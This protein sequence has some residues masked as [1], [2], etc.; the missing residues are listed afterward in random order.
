MLALVRVATSL[1]A[2]LPLFVWGS[3]AHP[4]IAAACAAAALA[5]AGW[6]AQ[7]VRRVGTL[8]DRPLV[9]VDVLF[10]LALMLAGTR[11]VVPHDHNVIATELVP[12]MLASAA[13]VGFGFMFGIFQAVAVAALMAGWVL[14]VIPDVTLKL[15]SDL[16]GFALWYV[17]AA[18]SMREFRA[19]ALRTDQAQQAAQESAVA[20]EAARQRERIHGEV[21]GRLLPIVERLIVGEPVT[22]QTISEARRAAR[23]ARQLIADP[24][25]GAELAGAPAGFA[26]ML[27]ETIDSCAGRLA[28]EP[29]LVITAEPGTELAEALCTAV[30]E[31]LRNVSRHAGPQPRA[32]LYVESTAE[33]GQVTVRDR[34]PGFDLA[35]IR[36]GGGFAS[37]FPAL[38]RHGADWHADSVPGR[39]T[40]V[41]ITWTPAEREPDRARQ[42]GAHG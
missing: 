9:I 11:A 15:P 23:R 28:L 33:R 1:F 6:F 37:T 20:A 7:R 22:E 3:L 5:E 4:W 16:L 35:A 8:R 40:T 34:G 27:H 12:T 32:N 41:T 26:A 36:P 29:V 30:G 38:R 24:R 25:A 18:L 31:A 17:V 21:H 10:C 14:A 42:A 13:I 2:C 39:G 19:M